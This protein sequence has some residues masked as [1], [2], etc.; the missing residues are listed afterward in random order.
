MFNLIFPIL[1]NSCIKNAQFKIFYQCMLLLTK[2]KQFSKLKDKKEV[3]VTL[4]TAIFLY[5]RLMAA[6]KAKY[7]R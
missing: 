7:C 5:D 1:T 3:G 4:L 6:S 2:V